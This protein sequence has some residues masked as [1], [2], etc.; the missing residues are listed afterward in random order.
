M[1]Y[2]RVIKDMNDET[3]TRVRIVGGVPEHFQVEMVL[4]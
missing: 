3:K 2:F 1:V 4:H